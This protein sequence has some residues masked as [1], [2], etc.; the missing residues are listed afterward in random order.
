MVVIMMMGR[1][2]IEYCKKVGDAGFMVIVVVVMMMMMVMV[3]QL[4]MMRRMVKN[5]TKVSDGD[6]FG[7]KLS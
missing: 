1:M 7:A 2:V 3:M 6:D 5:N 4:M